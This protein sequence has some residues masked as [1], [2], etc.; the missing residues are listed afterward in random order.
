[1]NILHIEDDIEL[2]DA[3]KKPFKQSGFIV[4]SAG[5]GEEGIM[6]VKSNNYDCVILDLALPAKDGLQVCKDIRYLGMF[7][8]I[9]VLSVK[10]GS[11]IKINLFKAGADDYVTKPFNFD[12]L[13][14][15]IKANLRRPKEIKH[16]KIRLADLEID[17]ESRTVMLGEE[18]LNL[19]NKEF[20]LLEYLVRNRGRVISR[21]ELLEHV[22]D[23]NADP[24]TNTVETHIAMLRKKLNGNHKIIHTI[25]NVGYKIE[26]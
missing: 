24:F 25:P 17:L 12:E 11:D 6:K 22:W 8:P 4:D 2:V 7:M 26:G 15:R 20:C 21:Q 5:S 19:N 3:L 16:T 10:V 18:Q 9:I 14:E 1:M 13:L 23:V